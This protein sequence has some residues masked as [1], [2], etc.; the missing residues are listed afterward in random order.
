VHEDDPVPAP[1]PFGA[2]RLQRIDVSET[3]AFLLLL[4]AWLVLQFVIL[5]RYG[6]AS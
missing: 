3:L 2:P 1:N 5:P 6:E 4:G